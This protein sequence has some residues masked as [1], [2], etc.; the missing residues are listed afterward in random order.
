[1]VWYSAGKGC[2]KYNFYHKVLAKTREDCLKKCQKDIRCALIAYA[3]KNYKC[4]LCSDEKYT[5]TT[6]CFSHVEIIAKGAKSFA[7]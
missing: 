1:M 2:F 3:E 6:S 7:N 4:A 5:H